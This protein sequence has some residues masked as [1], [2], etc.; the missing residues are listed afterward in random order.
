MEEDVLV[1]SEISESTELPPRTG[2]SFGSESGRGGST[3]EFSG[4]VR[5]KT[6]GI[7]DSQKHH[8]ASEIDGFAG[9]IEDVS[10]KLG[11]R[12]RSGQQHY[13]DRAAQATRSLSRSLREQRAEE[14]IDRA[15][16]EIEARP[17]VLVGGSL[18]LGFIGY[19]LFK[20]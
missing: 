18:L 14:L 19:R 11:E 3:H 16:K 4:T 1:G 12:G 8:L 10:R 2:S 20:E 9:L 7:L 5:R 13:A 17:S 15:R 6:M